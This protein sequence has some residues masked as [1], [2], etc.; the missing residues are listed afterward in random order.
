V[1][2]ARLVRLEDTLLNLRIARALTA[3]RA[4]ARELFAAVFLGK[5][6]PGPLQGQVWADLDLLPIDELFLV[7]GVDISGMTAGQLRQMC[8]EESA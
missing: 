7:G 4:V 8:L 6:S 5:L 3:A 1:R 2:E